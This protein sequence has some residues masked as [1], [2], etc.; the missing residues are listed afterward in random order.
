MELTGDAGLKAGDM[1]VK[2]LAFRCMSA[3]LQ[4]RPCTPAQM[5]T[6]VECVT[7]LCRPLSRDFISN[8]R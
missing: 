4:K 6:I 3:L 8:V 5:A 7:V 2:G 1:T